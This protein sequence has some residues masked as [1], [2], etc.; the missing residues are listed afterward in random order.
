MATVL[1]SF[2]N[3][4]LLADAELDC[5]LDDDWATAELQSA[6]LQ[7]LAAPAPE[8]APEPAPPTPVAKA[9]PT[10]SAVLIE[11]PAEV[12]GFVRTLFTLLRVC[13][14]VVIGWSRDGKVLLVR[15]PARFAAE[16]CPKFFRHKNFNSFTRLLNMYQFHKR[17]HEKELVGNGV[18]FAHESFMRGRE[19]LL[20]KIKRRRAPK[21][22]PADKKKRKAPAAKPA[23]APAWMRRVV[24]L[25]SEQKRLKAE[26]ER[27]RQNEAEVR[28]LR[29]QVAQQRAYIGQLSATLGGGLPN[30]AALNGLAAALMAAP[31]WALGAAAPPPPAADE[32]LDRGARMIRELLEASGLSAADVGALAPV[33]PPAPD[34]AGMEA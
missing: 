6:D 28:A 4:P 24:D 27:L 32:P 5:L 18:A 10:G 2:D 15:D 19:D 17:P 22:A 11:P 9:A 23:D 13:D 33:P 29:D 34:D 14:P 1:P 3:H 30:A 26:N 25:E 16:V 12:A 21:K 7:P 8:A 31:G 20:A